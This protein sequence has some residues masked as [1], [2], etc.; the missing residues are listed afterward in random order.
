MSGGKGH[1]PDFA[2]RQSSCRREPPRVTLRCGKG[3]STKGV[4]MRWLS[5]VLLIG[6]MATL[7]C[8]QTS[9]PSKSKELPKLSNDALKIGGKTFDQWIKELATKDPSKRE[10]AIRAICAFPSETAI[11]AI[12]ALLAEMRRPSPVDLSVRCNLC[13]AL[14]EL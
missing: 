13:L 7:A 12:P 8:A 11:K 9:S 3:T 10:T 6:S 5:A 4:V 14:T 2:I 1:Q